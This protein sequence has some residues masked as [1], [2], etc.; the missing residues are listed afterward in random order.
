VAGVIWLW[1]GFRELRCCG[2]SEKFL[3]NCQ[4]NGLLLVTFG[5]CCCWMEGFGEF[6]D[7]MGT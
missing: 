2:K 4:L 7:G 3:V 1:F 5:V 6:R